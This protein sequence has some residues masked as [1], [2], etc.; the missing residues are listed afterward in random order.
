MKKLLGSSANP[1]NISL[2]VKSVVVWLIP[3]IIM[4]AK[5]KNIELQQDDLLNFANVLSTVVASTMTL[6]GLARKFYYNLIK[7]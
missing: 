6:Y 5:F 7:K 1:E 2:T 4:L 3:G